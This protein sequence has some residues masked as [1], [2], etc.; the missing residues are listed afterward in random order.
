MIY[1]PTSS[2]QYISVIENMFRSITLMSSKEK[3]SYIVSKSK[4]PCF[5][6]QSTV[7]LVIMMNTVIGFTWFSLFLTG[8]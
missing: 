3:A 8:I 1:L 6:F 4:E 5:E 7:V 2:D